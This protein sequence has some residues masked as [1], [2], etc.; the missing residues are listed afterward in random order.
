MITHEENLRALGL[1]P[2]ASIEEIRQAYRDLVKV[3]HPDRFENDPRVRAKAEQKLKEITAAYE[4]LRPTYRGRSQSG[5][6]RPDQTRHQ[7]SPSAQAAREANRKESRGSAEPKRAAA[8][9]PAAKASVG[10]FA[11]PMLVVSAAVALFALSFAIPDR[12][13]Q[14]GSSAAT[15]EPQTS[16]SIST[17][18]P[19][20]GASSLQEPALRVAASQEPLTQAFKGTEAARAGETESADR[21][22]PSGAP[23]RSAPQETAR[24]TEQSA[25]AEHPDRSAM[26]AP[27]KPAPSTASEISLPSDQA[28]PSGVRTE[29]SEF[30][31]ALNSAPVT[32]PAN[33][34][35][36]AV[37]EGDL[38]ALGPGVTPPQLV[39]VDRPEYPLA[40]RRQRVEGTV[41]V[42]VLVDEIGRVTD[43]RL[44]HG[45]RQNV[46]IN[47]AAV[48]AAWSARFRPAMKDGVRVKTWYR[49]NIPFKL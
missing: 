23:P 15:L 38:V 48:V 21:Q 43:V 1:H 22:N 30:W 25:R 32:P 27:E 49:L 14:S 31:R 17:S 42:S 45:V 11:A 47:D 36:R 4:A 7:Q 3:W 44:E 16:D 28:N 8:K 37:Q 19:N 40:A 24:P 12:S 13:E 39:S 5:R 46:G 6:A 2:G 33:V 41:V 20:D 35:V 26:P 10:R 29:V 9:R 34:P 18:K